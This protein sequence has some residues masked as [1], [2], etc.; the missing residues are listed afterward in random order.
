M[1]RHK[2]ARCMV[3]QYPS[4]PHQ[5]RHGPRGY[6]H[7]PSYKPWL[8]DEYAFRCVYCLCRERWFPD[9]DD[10][11][12]VEHFDPQSLARERRT[13][14]DNLIY[15]CCQCNASKRDCD[16]LLN[17]DSQALATHLEVL[18][19]GSIRGLTSEGTA[20]IKVCRL[21]RPKLTAFRKGLLALVR[22]L[23]QHPT[24]EGGRLLRHILGFPDNLP[25]LGV[26]RPPGGNA[27]PD[28]VATSAHAQHLQGKLGETY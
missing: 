16:W 12:S 6:R 18:K 3:F 13:E 11:L 22:A 20:C 26:L 10:H 2:E 4:V 28:G 15:A 8:R 27:R 5:R 21:D 19:D 25:N 24:A 7:H 23:A 17:P 1:A 9:G 14:Y